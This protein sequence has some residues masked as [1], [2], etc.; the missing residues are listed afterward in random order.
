MSKYL[1][2]APAIIVVVVA[3]ILAANGFRGRPVSMGID[4]GTTY[5]AVVFTI[6][7]EVHIAKPDANH[8]TLHS[9]VA[10]VEGNF[11]VGREA[12][13]YAGLPFSHIDT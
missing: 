9:V 13:A 7:K 12:H 11:V 8:S 4:L 3:A 2:I 1:V 10:I 6:S 5:S